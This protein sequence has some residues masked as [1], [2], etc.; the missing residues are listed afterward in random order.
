M[1]RVTASEARRNWFRIL[2]E[3]AAGETVIIQRGG[4]QILLQREPEREGD[5][6]DYSE[7]IQ[8][9]QVE[10]ADR[11][12]WRWEGEEGDLVPEDEP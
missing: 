8:V 6:P 1:K 12:R 10:E 2:D 11:W 7:A 9:P 3:V 5:L 4:R